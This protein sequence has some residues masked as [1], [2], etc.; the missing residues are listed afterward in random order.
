MELKGSGKLL[1]VRSYTKDDETKV[2]YSV[3]TGSRKNDGLMEKPEIATIIE[4][5]L[6]IK[7]P[8]FMM[9]VTFDASVEKFGDKTISR[10]T[11][12]PADE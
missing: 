12:I 4:E 5:D 11:N 7:N 8:T 9:D 3:L 2:I 6:V 10:Y 1:G